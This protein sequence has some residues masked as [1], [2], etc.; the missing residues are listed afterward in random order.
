MADFT[1][2]LKERR[3][4][5]KFT[6]QPVSDEDLNQ[7]LEAVMWSPSWANTQCWEVVAVKDAAVKE[8][9]QAHI[10]PKNP[11]TKAMVAAPVVLV[12]CG[13]KQSSGYYNGQVTTKH[14]DWIMFDLGIACQSI[15][16]AAKDLGL[17]TVIVGLF[18]HDKVNETIGVPE[19]FECA[20]MIPMGHPDQD[21]KAPK[22][23]PVSEFSHSDKW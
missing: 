10:G 12:L 5:R 11:A 1:Q 16:L 3:S 13:K 14:G 17:G 19:G 23:R 8:Q 21:P 7:V 20:V 4:V 6:D 22:R 9:L 18:D 15:C 2:V